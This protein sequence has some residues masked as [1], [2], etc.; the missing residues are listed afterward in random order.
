MA[1]PQGPCCAIR[2]VTEHHYSEGPKGG[3]NPFEFRYFGPWGK[4]VK[5]MRLFP[6]V[7][8]FRIARNLQS[9]KGSTILVI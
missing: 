1:A 6:A 9:T 2:F 4:Q 8:A 7:K 3:S 5:N